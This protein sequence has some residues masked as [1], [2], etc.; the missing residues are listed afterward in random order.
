MGELL[1]VEAVLVACPVCEAWPMVVI[2]RKSWSLRL[3][4][5]SFVQNANLEKVPPI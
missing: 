2:T 5:T 1:S 3:T 4:V